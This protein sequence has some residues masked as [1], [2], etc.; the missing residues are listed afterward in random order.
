MQVYKSVY[1][2]RCGWSGRVR[3]WIR[4][5]LS[6]FNP[7]LICDLRIKIDP[8]RVGP[9]DQV[10]LPFAM[11]LFYFLLACNRTEDVVVAF[12]LNKKMNPI[13][14]S[15]PGNSVGLVL[16]YSTDKIIVHA[17]VEVAALS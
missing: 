5:A 11:P 15:K 14:R 17:T 12:E 3:S 6:W 16:R 8:F 7:A 10:D 4:T 13:S 1:H 2:Q 9:L